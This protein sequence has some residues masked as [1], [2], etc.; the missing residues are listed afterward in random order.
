M[1]LRFLS[2]F[3]IFF[4][5]IFA[6]STSYADDFF[7]PRDI[8][9]EEDYAEEEGEEAGD[10]EISPYQ[11]F[12]RLNINIRE[13]CILMHFDGRRETLF[14]IAEKHNVKDPKC[15]SC[16]NLFKTFKT[17]CNVTGK[18]K[19]GVKNRYLKLFPPTPTPTADPEHKDDHAEEHKE[20]ESHDAHGKDHGEDHAKDKKLDPDE[21]QFPKQRE[22]NPEILSIIS[23]SFGGLAKDI[24]KM[25]SILPAIEKLKATL[26]DP[27]NKTNSEHEYFSILASYIYAPFKRY[28]KIRE[29]KKKQFEKKLEEQERTM[30]VDDLFEF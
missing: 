3:L 9:E 14:N 6:V 18:Y 21:I 12:G 1:K 22:P 26:E 2:M 29:T 25:D 27:S 10:S 15:A 5:A 8:I 7:K 23:N 16:K 28:V 4:T 17:A 19:K 20:G 24:D 30:S 11:R 13:A